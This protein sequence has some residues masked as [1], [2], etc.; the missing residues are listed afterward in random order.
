MEMNRQ[1]LSHEALNLSYL[2]TSSKGPAI[3]ALHAHWMEASTFRPLAAALA[4]AWRVIA[5][6]QRGHGFSSHAPSYTR[7]DYF[8]DLDALLHHLGLEQVVLLGNSLGGVNAYQY[9]A[10]RPHRVV[11][12]VIEDIG[13]E[14]DDDVSMGLPWAGLFGTRAELEAVIGPKLLPALTESV[15]E[16]GDGWRLAFDPEEVVA[17]QA[18]LNGDHWQDWLASTCPAL[19]VR[20]KD[21]PLT[22][23][24]HLREMARRRPNTALVELEG[25]HA[26]HQDNPGGF[27]SALTNFLSEL[28]GLP[29]KQADEVQ[30]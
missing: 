17:S 15:R 18:R 10:R 30:H 6:D 23:A 1:A 24:A 22:K 5:L 20:G 14:I 25:G 2:D 28:P 11:G 9:A 8:G 19:I 3:V 7:G 4:P 27:T 12:L 29:S 21:S 26:V 13:A 16:T